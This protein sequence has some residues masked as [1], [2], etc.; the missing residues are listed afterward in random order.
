MRNKYFLF[1][2][3]LLSVICACDKVQNGIT[4]KSKSEIFSGD[5]E[6]GRGDRKDSLDGNR[7]LMKDT[8]VYVSGVQFDEGYDWRRD[9]LFNQNEGVLFLLKDGEKILDINASPS[10][11][12]S[13]SPGM[14]H[15]LEGHII[16]EYVKDG[17]TII[18]KD[19]ETLFSYSGS[20]YLCGVL[21][22]GNDVLT[23][24]QNRSGQG[25][26]L[27]KNG[28]IMMQKQ[29]GTIANNFD[30]DPLFPTGALYKDQGRIVFC[31]MVS[32]TQAG[33]GRQWM[34]VE[35]LK[36]TQVMTSKDDT[37]WYDI[38]MKNGELKIE[39]NQA[40]NG[41]SMFSFG[42]GEEAV[43]YKKNDDGTFSLNSPD[44]KLRM[45]TRYYLFS[46]RNVSVAGRDVYMAMTPLDRDKPSVLLHLGKDVREYDFN[47]YFSAVEVLIY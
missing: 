37:E 3:L 4:H 20:E 13:T 41:Y 12:V 30:D 8:V 26:S 33:S 10:E 6:K 47:G 11:E 29:S 15:L 35:D 23:L 38:R 40:N 45:R 42:S 21:L 43:S 7:G 32:L 36:E 5:E 31:Y 28:E 18:K 24:G 19:G 22:D 34:L 27:R 1:F 39:R 46:F 16:T 2:G 44:T 9:S 25:F 14:A 17:K